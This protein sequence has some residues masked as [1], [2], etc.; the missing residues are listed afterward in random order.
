MPSNYWLKL[1]HELLHDPK[2]AQLDSDTWR[3]CIEMFLFAG[4]HGT[5]QGYL[6]SIT[7]MAWTLH[8]TPEE[9]ASDIGKLLELGILSRD[10]DGRAYVTQFESRQAPASAAARQKRY[11]ERSHKAQHYGNEPRNEPVTIRNTDLDTDIEELR[12]ESSSESEVAAA[13]VTPL[14]VGPQTDDDDETETI[15]RIFCLWEDRFGRLTDIQRQEVA[16]RLDEYGASRLCEALDATIANNGRSI[17]YLDTVLANWGKGK[18]RSRASPANKLD[19][20]EIDWLAIADATNRY[21]EDDTD[22]RQDDGAD[23]PG[24]A[25]S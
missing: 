24:V 21:G 4:E 9:L 10:E 17:A 16:Y 20:D 13:P 18:P 7:D 3:R 14:A 2:M 22:E 5:K 6:P 1:Y 25:P 8:S 12:E 11:R 23:K 19:S 15:A